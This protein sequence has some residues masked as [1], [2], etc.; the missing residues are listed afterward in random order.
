MQAIFGDTTKRAFLPKLDS[1][2]THCKYMNPQELAAIREL[3]DSLPADFQV[4]EQG[5]SQAVLEEYYSFGKDLKGMDRADILAQ[6]ADWQNL[7]LGD[8]K[9]LLVVLAAEGDVKS[10]RQLEAILEA[11]KEELGKFGAVTM[12][13]ARMKLE[14]MFTDTPSGFI[15]S[16][17]GGKG[18]KLRYY[19][20]LTSLEEIT[21]A[22][23][24]FIEGEILEVCRNRDS[25]MEDFER[26]T[27]YVLVRILVSVE[28]AIGEVIEDI[29][30]ACPFLE[31]EFICTNVEKPTHEFI[32]RWIND[33]LD[34]EIEEV[35][36]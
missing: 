25:E 13:Y 32:S 26:A 19:F 35:D 10:F 9:Q 20:V 23:A 3:L 29:S 16:G 14:S 11:K 8:L 33:E 5:V 34:E 30:E 22:R 27:H 31:K 15:L 12:M 1:A 24:R 7:A 18:N 6:Q 21:D 2:V 4:M 36:I 28:E 17:L